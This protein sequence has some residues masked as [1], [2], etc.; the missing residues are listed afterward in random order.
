MRSDRAGEPRPL[1]D[2]LL[3]WH[4][5]AANACGLPGDAADGQTFEPTNANVGLSAEPIFAKT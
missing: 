2:A 4:G 1:I 3:N 5:F